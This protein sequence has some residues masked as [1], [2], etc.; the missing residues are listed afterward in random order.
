MTH[1]GR[2][3][4]S[5]DCDSPDCSP[6]RALRRERRV[7]C[8]AA[9]V[10]AVALSGCSILPP[11]SP[12]KE[13]HAIDASTP[14]TL[15]AIAASSVASGSESGFSLLPVASGDYEA[16][17][18][19]VSYAEKSLD[20]Q[21]FYWAAD[22][23]GTYL[24]NRLR[25]A[26]ARGVR[27]RLLVDDLNSAGTDDMLKAFSHEPNVEVRLFNPFPIGRSSTALRLIASLN[28]L[29][30]VNHRMHNKLFVADNAVAIFGGRNTGDEYFMRSNAGNFVDFDVVSA[31]KV[32]GDLSA[33]FDDYWNSKF[34]YPIS[35]IVDADSLREEAKF[36]HRLS[37][38]APPDV[39]E[40]VPVIMQPYTGIENQLADGKLK[41]LPAQAIVKADPTDKVAGTRMKDRSGTVRAFIAQ[42][43]LKAKSELFIS[44]PYFVPGEDGMN[45]LRELRSR[46][47]VVRVLTNSLA[48]TDEPSV[49]AGYRRY[50][51]RLLEIGVEIYELSPGLTTRVHRLGRFGSSIGMLHMKI[52][53]L[54]RRW[55]FVGSMNM[56]VRSEKYNTELGVLIDNAELCQDFIDLVHYE[57]S[58]YKLR[59]NP[60]SG[61]IEWVEGE[62]ADEKVY[63]D[64]PETSWWRRTKAS[65][66]GE[67]VPEGWL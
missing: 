58:A 33:T 39:D 57:G 31:G 32:V 40:T 64:E 50:R 10:V 15:R 34:S 8:I 56:D 60:K 24:L 55:L 6:G 62:G 3:N 54:D 19:L 2:Q 28:E 53:A 11:M 43:A 49:H 36:R 21:T 44:S 25:A 38:A 45:T 26:A 18:A 12:V 9:A 30:R 42:A 35:D 47:V 61:A 5:A 48:A 52:A 27:V 22:S 41:L 66:L 7:F 17:L 13:T 37:E 67:L 16:R 1:L 59:L 29:D 46:G 63:E 14:T 51:H 23:T 65:V 4:G 20:V